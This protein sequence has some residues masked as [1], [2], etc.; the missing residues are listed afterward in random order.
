MEM[1]I[2]TAGL[3]K[4]LG[5]R[6]I[7]DGLDIC[8]PSGSIYGFLG[9]NGAGKTT[10]MRLL[11]GLVRADA[12]TVHLL[13]KPLRT[14]RIALLR[15]IG[16]FIESPAVYDH[17]SGRANLDL[18]RRMMS[19]PPREADRVLEITGMAA[20]ARRKVRDYSLGMRQRIALARALLGRPEL[21]LLDEPT[22]GLDP[23]GI[24]DMRWLIRSLPQQANCTV[25]LSSHLLA[26]VEQVA[27]HVG[28]LRAG[29]LVKEGPLQMLLGA[30]RNVRV[31]V[32]DA[33]RATTVLAAKGFAAEK[34]CA[35]SL[36]VAVP[37]GAS[38]ADISA[39]A[40]AALVTAGVPVM[41]LCE[42]KRS[43][44]E[45]Y[46]EIDGPRTQERGLAA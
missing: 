39:Q 14:D 5:G 40:N 25:F 16:A 11:L 38:A 13:G 34:A 7:I 6:T 28:L 23:E 19:L 46:R 32:D 44:E 26:E 12:G 17:L 10:A 24:A 22:N 35:A 4:R 18:A 21:L 31:T 41:R 29:S 33:A 15:R 43:L 8:V 20:H 30:G 42:E 1:A 2:R 9:P 27:D 3:R 36:L 37:D 45:I